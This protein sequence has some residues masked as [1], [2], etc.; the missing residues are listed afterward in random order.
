LSSPNSFIMTAS[1]AEH[2]SYGC[3]RKSELTYFGRAMYNEQLRQTYSFEQA[4]A[5]ARGVIERREKEA[6]K[7]DGYSNPQ[8]FVGEKIKAKLALL[9][10]RLATPALPSI[11]DK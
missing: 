5:V 2:T 1:D 4:H 7:E 6:G 8:I 11:T 10:M 9:E 3:G